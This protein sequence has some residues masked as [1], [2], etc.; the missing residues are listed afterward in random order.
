MHARAPV[1]PFNDNGIR[2]VILKR[3]Y[4]I[5]NDSDLETTDA[6][7]LITAT[8]SEPKVISPTSQM[9]TKERYIVRFGDQSL[10]LYGLVIHIIIE[11]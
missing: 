3:C 2:Y 11:W 10:Y 1:V 8:T 4:R 5:A 7:R 6:I 9:W